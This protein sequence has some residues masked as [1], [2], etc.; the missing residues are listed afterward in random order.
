MEFMNFQTGLSFSNV[1]KIRNII[2]WFLQIKFAFLI[3]R[4]NGVE[5]SY[6]LY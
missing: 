6:L 1:L 2:L 4:E 3:L 5:L